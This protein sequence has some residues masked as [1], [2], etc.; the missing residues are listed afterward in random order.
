M[1]EIAQTLQRTLLVATPLLLATVGEIFAERAGILNLGL[2]GLISV[3][4]VAAF[5]VTSL[6]GN[7]WAG[8]FAALVAGF[9]LALIHAFVSVTL[10][11]SQ[12]VSGLALSMLGMGIAGMWGKP[13]IGQS[14]PVKAEPLGF[15]DSLP[16]VG[17]VLHQDLFFWVAL[18]LALGAWFFLKHT[19]WGIQIRSVGENPK[20]SDAQGIPVDRIKYLC[21]AFGGALSGLAGAQLALSYTDSW[22]EGLSGGKGWIAIALTIFALW[23]PLR[24]IWGALL[25]GGIFVLQYRLQPLGWSPNLLAM[26]PYLTTLIILLIYGLKRN[27]KKMDGPAMLGEIYKRGER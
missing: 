21:V 9:F 15:L 24:A 6:T 25:F 14:L 17:T 2:E 20:A 19:L 26:L 27:S 18:V 1:D 13:F 12:V 10:R 3:G 7:L 16:V 22:A 5:V 23:S 8:I 11:A 4:A